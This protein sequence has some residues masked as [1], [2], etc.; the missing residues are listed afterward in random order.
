[1]ERQQKL[2][3]RARSSVEDNNKEMKRFIN[4]NSVS[5][6]SYIPSSPDVYDKYIFPI[7]IHFS[8]LNNRRLILIAP[9]QSQLIF[10]YVQLKSM[11][12]W[13]RNVYVFRF[14]F[15]TKYKILKL[16]ISI[17]FLSSLLLFCHTL[18]TKISAKYFLYFAL[19]KIR[20]CQ[21]CQ[22]KRTFHS[23]NTQ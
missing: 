15:K 12:I 10:Y 4:T 1:M 6:V 2:V 5:W 3:N 23:V 20:K 8:F 19:Q 7:I 11:C 18:K 16:N 17:K 9:C 13:S 21:F 22:S 14:V